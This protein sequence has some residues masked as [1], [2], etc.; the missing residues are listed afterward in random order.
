MNKFFA[1]VFSTIVATS[2]APAFA[3]KPDCTGGYKIFIN[4]V[5]PF[6]DK[7]DDKD[8]VT[9]MRRGL[10]VFDECEAGDN[11]SPNGI[12]DQ[13]AAAMEAASA[14]QSQSV[15]GAAQ[16]DRVGLI[17]QH[18]P[19]KT[20]RA[21]RALRE[22]AGDATG[23]ILPMTKSEMWSVPKQNLK[24]LQLLAAKSGVAIR[25]LDDQASNALAPMN[26]DAKMTG[27]QNKMMQEAKERPSTKGVTMMALPEPTV[28]E[29]ALTRGMN[30]ADPDAIAPVITLKLNSTTTIAVR[31]TNIVKDG[32]SY[33][34]HGAIEGTGEPVTL[35]YWPQG[36]LSGNINH[37]GH[38]YSVQSLGGG[39]HAVIEIEPKMLP[40]EHAPMDSATKQKMNLIDDP[41]VTSGDANMLMEK[42]APLKDSIENLRDVQP[43][44]P[45]SAKPNL[46]AVP[47][48]SAPS[49]EPVTI[50]L[51]VAY[52]NAAA[53]HYTDIGKDL[54]ALAVAEANQSFK[55]SGIPNLQIKLVRAYETNYVEKGTHFDH[56]Y[57]FTEKGDG[58]LD[59]IH[60]LRDKHRADVAL[61]I[62]HD[63]NGCGLAAGVAAPAERA[64]AVVHH[65]C[66][67]ATYSLAH[68]IGH[69]IGARH[70]PGL[71]NNADPFTY[72]HGFVNGNK[73][74][75][76]MG[77]EHSCGGCPRLPVWSNP[78]VLIQG[79]SAGNEFSNN[80]RV[81][82]EQAAR[83]AGFR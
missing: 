72:G 49:T 17:L 14:V 71:D 12:W 27:S 1:A 5:S 36:R 44:R 37:A 29:Y 54:I 48:V 2:A 82:R 7:A 73:W 9:S 46:T 83:V 77:Y 23:E 30:S 59:E 53:S 6:V 65:G 68:E 8:L 51:I 4:R 64:F 42:M 55:A 47:A 40:P 52:T 25:Q 61:L 3:A 69:I 57:Q 58:A 62:V 74:R 81:L 67:A 32:D 33:I 28:L 20:S 45:G 10:S 34:W 41:L 26:P 15:E 13:I 70:D 38:L 43:T 78:D 50:N 56:V 31:R 19:L 76:V 22:A 16:T 11:F 18:L 75:T 80:A 66:A 21:Y 24:Q 63:L 79:E 60:K 39:M 35:V